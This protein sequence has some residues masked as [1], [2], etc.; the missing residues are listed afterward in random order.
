V[1]L[2]F[3]CAA[4]REPFAHEE[5]FHQLG[6]VWIPYRPRRLENVYFV[7]AVLVR[8]GPLN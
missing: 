1:G 2:G 3:D 5:R 4:E 8:A 7:N 6:P